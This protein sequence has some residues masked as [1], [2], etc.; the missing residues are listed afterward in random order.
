MAHN[1]LIAGDIVI[2]DIP[3]PAAATAAAS[4]FINRVSVVNT[5]EP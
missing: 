5:I 1:K 3:P 2:R 4:T